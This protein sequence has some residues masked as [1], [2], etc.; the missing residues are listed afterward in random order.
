MQLLALLLERLEVLLLGGE[1]LL[2]GSHLIRGLDGQVLVAVVGANALLKADDVLDHHIGAVE[3]QRE[4]EGEA[5]EVH[6]ALG[7]K[8]AGLYFGALVAEDDSSTAASSLLHRL[9]QFHLD[10]VDTV[11]R[12]DEEDEDENKGNLEPVLNLTDGLV[13]GDESKNGTASVV[14]QGNNQEHE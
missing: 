5:A 14:R 7:I 12:I 3:D 2:E 9:S 4:E 10:T 6:V 8:L 13:L 1:L 11:D